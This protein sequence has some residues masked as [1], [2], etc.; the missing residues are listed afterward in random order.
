MQQSQLIEKNLEV[1]KVNLQMLKVDNN[2][3]MMTIALKQ[4]STTGT[5]SVMAMELRILRLRS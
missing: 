3:E 5:L 2:K 4:F 1:L